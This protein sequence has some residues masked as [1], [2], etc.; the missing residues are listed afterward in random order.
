MVPGG[1][2]HDPLDDHVDGMPV[3][4][5]HGGLGQH[6]AVRPLSPCTYSA[7]S[8]GRRIGRGAAGMDRDVAA[9]GQRQDLPRVALGPRQRHVAGDRGDRQDL[10][11]VGRAQRQQD[12]DGV[13]LA[14]VAVEDDLVQGHVSL[15]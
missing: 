4:Q 2:R 7:V 6:G 5:R 8:S 15:R 9:A 13:V 11:L 12:G 3:G 1:R 10:D 14:G